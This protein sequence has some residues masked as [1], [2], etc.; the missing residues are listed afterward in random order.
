MSRGSL[1]GLIAGIATA[2]LL[3]L[4]PACSDARAQA[5]PFDPT[6]KSIA[7]LQQ[8]LT[9]GAVTSRQLVEAYL[10]RIEAY[11]R[12]GPDLQAFIALNPRALETA[13]ALDRER[14]ERGPRGPL[15][16]IP[17]AIKDNFDTADMP[18]TGASIALATHQPARDAFQVER[19]RA[20]GAVVIGKT[21]LHELAAGIL[22]VSSLGGH[23]RNPYDPTRNPGGSSGGT[24]AAVAA[25]F[26]A[27]GL[28]SDT[29]GSIRIPAAHN[30]LVGLRPT[31][32]LSS[33]AGVIPLALTQDVAGPLARS[34][35]D[36]AI[37]LDAT[38][39]P[40]PRD[41]ATEAGRGR[42]PASY[43]TGLDAVTL[44]GAR[45][46]V[47]ISLF[48]DAPADAESA[49]IVRAAL[50][51]MR[52]AG[53]V[54]LDIE[55]PGM[56]E[57]LRGAGVID[58]EFKFDL[59]DYLAASP[60]PPVRSLGEIL[61][62]GLHHE[63]LT[64]A[65][66]RRNAPELRNTDAYR[67]ALGR[68]AEVTTLV[69][70]VM[71]RERFDA[72]VYPTMRRRPSLIGE[73]QAGSTCQLS[74]VTGLPALALPA[75]FT[76]DELPVGF[77]LLGPAW[78]EARLLSMGRAYERLAAVRRPPASTPALSSPEPRATR[79]FAAS[80]GMPAPP[81][82]RPAVDATFEWDDGR[83]SLSYAIRVHGVDAADVLLGAVRRE[84]SGPIVAVL[85]RAG[86][87]A[88]IG[89]VP[90]SPASRD[91][92]L[93]GRLVVQLFTRADPF[94]RPPAAV[95]IR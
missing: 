39:G 34:V 70:E 18:T 68:R 22:T 17:I 45:L 80:S 56:A 77:E 83:G 38:V 35:D 20:A 94:G 60:A 14:R 16:G 32:G 95:T 66:R 28:G 65:F 31:W 92:L 87:T 64:G 43:R 85:L 78:S 61:D 89:S 30:N 55:I 5:T 59:A 7:E 74:A 15:H 91:A 4:T 46:G 13:D 73:A 26:A 71:D 25:S 1:A 79:R 88:A 53:A 82:D 11:D 21:N 24:S 36:V 57:P 48:G 19:L 51:R 58:H 44:R 67:A 49:A 90:I 41:P 8:A 52:A 3:W 23:T 63:A 93:A 47:L 54:V 27:A 62:R 42:A 50:D 10:A 12:S 37:L 29:C 40:D 75:G 2:A 72:L 86:E 33:R 6:E 69:T 76:T 84:D 9:S 81:A